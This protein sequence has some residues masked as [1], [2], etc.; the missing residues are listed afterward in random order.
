MSVRMS[1]KVNA[2]LDQVDPIWHSIRAEAEEAT[3]N[4]PVLG[5]FLYA[6]I[7]NQPSLEEAVMHRIAERLGH[8]DV[9]A[10]ILHQT[11]DTMLE[12]N[13]EWSHVLRV[14]I[15]AVYDRD[16]AY[17][18]FMDPVLYL[19]G[20]H[21]IQTHRLAH[22]LYKQGRKDFAYYLQ[23]RSSSIFQTDIHPAARLGSGLFLDHA[24]GLVV[25]ETAVVEDNVSILHG[26]T[27]GGTGKSSGDRHPKIRQGVLIG[28]GA[29]IL[30]NIQV[31]Q[32]SKI[33]AGSVVLKS[34]PHNVTVAGVPA[35]IIGETGCTEPSRVMDQMLGDGI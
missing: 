16:P 10:D 26:V 12:A 25:G 11:F 9:S 14:D 29:K 31:G 27:L 34:V 13:P 22:W 18:R 20:F 15:Q 7:L 24:T 6:T 2:G 32:C 3:R 35:R 23:S 8:P 30:G 4:D 21:A 33:A 28:A 1:S 5:A 19:K 17:S